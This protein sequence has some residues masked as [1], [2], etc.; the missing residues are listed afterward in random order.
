M[1]NVQAATTI[2]NRLSEVEGPTFIDPITI[3]L[4][5]N[6][7]S[8]IIKVI[9]IYQQCKE[10]KQGEVMQE[11]CNYPDWRTR[12]LIK[13][14]IRKNV[15]RATYWEK[16]DQICAAILHCGANTDVY[17]LQELWDTQDN[18]EYKL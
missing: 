10:N 18:D 12:R 13:R 6:I 1:N 5:V 2:Q 11:V 8:S 16:G 3:M 9:K 14:H 15:D 17:Q 4:I 7:I